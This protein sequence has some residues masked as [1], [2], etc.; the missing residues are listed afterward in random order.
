MSCGGCGSSGT[1]TVRDI[2][3]INPKEKL[4]KCVLCIV[5]SAMGTLVGWTF[6]FCFLFLAPSSTTFLSFT[7]YLS[8]FFT[9]LLSAHGIAYLVRKNKGKNNSPITLTESSQ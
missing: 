9:A 6:Y 1:I 7:L 8:L 2:L 5:S 4:G 3:P